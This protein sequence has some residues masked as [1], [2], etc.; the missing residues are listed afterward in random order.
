MDDYLASSPIAMQLSERA[1]DAIAQLAESHT[2]E[3]LRLTKTDQFDWLPT[4]GGLIRDLAYDLFAPLA[5]YQLNAQ[6]L[7][8]AE[9]VLLGLAYNSVTWDYHLAAIP[10]RLVYSPECRGWRYRRYE[11]PASSWMQG[12]SMEQLEERLARFFIVQNV[13]Q[14]RR[15]VTK[16]EFK[17]EFDR[18]LSFG[19][20]RD[21]DRRRLGVLVNPL[22]GF[23]PIDRPVYWRVLAVQ[24]RL[25]STLA[26]RPGKVIFEDN[27]S[28]Q[29][30]QLIQNVISGQVLS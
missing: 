18:I 1:L 16:E 7:T 17:A 9:Q 19:F 30:E 14:D 5:L 10:P 6:A 15:L 20:D 28:E 11:E 25:Y 2:W 23:A 29:A 27:L 22:L 24:Q 3:A 13:D 4:S 21:Q 8:S 26:G 12:L